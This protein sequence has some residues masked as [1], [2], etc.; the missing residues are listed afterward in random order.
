MA[1]TVQPITA[2]EISTNKPTNSLLPTLSIGQHYH[3][4]FPA[5]V[6]WASPGRSAVS[7]LQGIQVPGHL[8][9]RQC[10]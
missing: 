2:T 5:A 1:N 7:D 9:F 3:S 8:M 10:E 6:Y 4:L